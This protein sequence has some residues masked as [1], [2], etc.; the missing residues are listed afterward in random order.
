MCVD[1]YDQLSFIR[2]TFFLKMSLMKATRR[3][4]NN[5]VEKVFL[6]FDLSRLRSLLSAHWKQETKTMRS[7]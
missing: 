6:E 5:K 3:L 1:L 7:I 2:F 4:S